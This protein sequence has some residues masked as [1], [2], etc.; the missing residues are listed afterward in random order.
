MRAADVSSPILA[1]ASRFSDAG[2]EIN[3]RA[4]CKNIR[5]GK[6]T[7]LYRW[8]R[9]PDYY[10]RRRGS[11]APSVERKTG[12]G[13]TGRLFAKP[14]R[15]T[16][17]RDRSAQPTLVRAHNRR[18]YQGHPKLSLLIRPA[19]GFHQNGRCARS[20]IQKRSLF[21]HRPHSGITDRLSKI[22]DGHIWPMPGPATASFYQRA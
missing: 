7:H 15:P 19:N 10:G 14:A 21:L 2:G 1:P 13:G 17:A 18:D 3:E 22:R 12:R 6:E 11:T 16:R 8:V 4:E 5:F 9:C 20:P